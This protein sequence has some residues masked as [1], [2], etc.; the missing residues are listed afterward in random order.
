M[1]ESLKNDIKSY[2]NNALM[3]DDF[4]SLLTDKYIKPAIQEVTDLYE[5]KLEEKDRKISDLQDQMTIYEEKLKSYEDAIDSQEQYS[6][7]NCLVIQ[8][9]G[10]TEPV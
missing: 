7:R 3:S 8:G 9:E 6:R 2:I 1:D 10:I 4:H 5:A